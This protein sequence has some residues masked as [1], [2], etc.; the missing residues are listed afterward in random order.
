MLSFEL[1][2][3]TLCQQV[4]IEDI[5]NYS[6]FWKLQFKY[7][8]S[9]VLQDSE[10]SIFVIVQL[11]WGSVWMDIFIF[12]PHIVTNLQSLRI[13]PFLVKLLLYILLSFL[14]RSLRIDFI[15]IFSSF[16]LFYFHL[17]FLEQ[18]GLGL[19]SHIVTSVTWWHSHKIDHKTWENLVKDLRT[20]DIIQ[21]GHHM[22]TSW[23]THGC[24]E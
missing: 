1:W 5:M 3:H 9:N 19:I 13:P 15:F 24:L 6:S 21:H 2:L 22:L 23:T 20:N 11:L 7:F 4:L 16:L 10:W 12:Q 14:S 17:L 8:Q 18:L